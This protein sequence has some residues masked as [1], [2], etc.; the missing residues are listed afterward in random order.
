MGQCWLEL[1]GSAGAATSC[2]AESAEEEHV[3]PQM[4]GAKAAASGEGTTLA[5]S[6]SFLRQ[7]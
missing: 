5:P 1:C 3:F 7:F 2:A 4:E 6:P